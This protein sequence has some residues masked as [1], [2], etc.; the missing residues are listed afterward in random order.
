MSLK[1]FDTIKNMSKL[2]EAAEDNGEEVDG[3]AMANDMTENPVQPVEDD[4]NPEVQADSSDGVFISKDIKANFAKTILNALLY[5][6]NSN[7]ELFNKLKSISPEDITV[8]NAD[9]VIKR[10]TELCSKNK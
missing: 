2:Y 7:D 8:K 5:P 3:A 6:V 9:L 4:T 1:A 10:V